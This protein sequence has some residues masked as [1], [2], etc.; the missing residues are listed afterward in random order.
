MALAGLHFGRATIDP[1]AFRPLSDRAGI[2]DGNCRAAPLREHGHIL[3]ATRGAAFL[4]LTL[5]MTALMGIPILSEL[6][7]ALDWIAIAL[8]SV[9]VC[10]VKWRSH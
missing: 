1:L 3:G 7:S 5:A 2:F 4:A 6:P 9:D 10:V 8:I